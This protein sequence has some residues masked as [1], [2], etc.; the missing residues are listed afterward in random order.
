MNIK[1]VLFTLLPWV[2]FFFICMLWYK[3]SREAEPKED[4]GIVNHNMVI[5]KIEAMGKLELV[6]FYIKDIVENTEELD[7]WPDPR[8]I[9]MVSGEVVGC[10]DLTKIDSS[11]VDIDMDK[12]SIRLPSPEVC[13]HKINHQESKVYNLENKLLYYKDAQLIDKAYKQAEN[14]LLNAASKMKILEQTK[15][16]AQIILKPLLEELSG[17]KKV[18]ITFE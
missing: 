3:F 11:K 16:N 1:R 7:W 14:Q 15:A 13:Y 6:R 5:E 18:V 4:K 9:L 12:I 17:G 10:V 8:V 2:L